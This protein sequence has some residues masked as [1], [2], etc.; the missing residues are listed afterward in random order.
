MHTQE[1][2]YVFLKNDVTQRDTLLC[3]FISYVIL[4]VP[5]AAD[6]PYK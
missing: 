1:R 6:E 4:V 2:Y 3:P 5:I